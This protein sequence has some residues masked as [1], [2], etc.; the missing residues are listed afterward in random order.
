MK[1]RIVMTNGLVAVI[2]KYLISAHLY[3][4]TCVLQT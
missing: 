2:G 3:S 1:I 4:T